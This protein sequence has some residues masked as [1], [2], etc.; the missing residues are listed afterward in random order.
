MAII[1]FKNKALSPLKRQGL[2]DQQAREQAPG[3]WRNHKILAK[4]GKLLG[5][6]KGLVFNKI[7]LIGR[8]DVEKKCAADLRQ[9]TPLCRMSV[10]RVSGSLFA[11]DTSVHIW[12]SMMLQAAFSTANRPGMETRL[13]RVNGRVKQLRLGNDYGSKCNLW[14][15]PTS[16]STIETPAS[17]R[18][19]SEL[20]RVP[21]R[22]LPCG[23][24]GTGNLSWLRLKPQKSSSV[25]RAQSHGAALASLLG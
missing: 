24:G 25:F 10:Q 23:L 6:V 1:N 5:V 12:R 3:H 22:R 18:G 13:R 19:S 16:T 21:V 7:Y 11:R 9:K 8:A 15:F 14:T 4:V 17:W 20:S 2:P